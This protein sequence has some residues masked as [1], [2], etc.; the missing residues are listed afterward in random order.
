MAS[1]F[2]TQDALDAWKLTQLFIN[3]VQDGWFLSSSFE[4][5]WW[6]DRNPFLKN[7]DIMFFVILFC[8]LSGLCTQ[9]YSQV[10]RLWPFMPASYGWVLAL[11]SY[12]VDGDLDQRLWCM[13]LLVNFWCFRLVY[14]FHRKGGYNFHGEDYRWPYLRA[15]INNWFLMEVFNLTFIAFYQHV[16]LFLIALPLYVAY[17]T[18]CKEWQPLDTVAAV[19]LFLS[20]VGETIADQQQWNFH[21]RKAAAK[22]KAQAKGLKTIEDDKDNDVKRGFLS[23]SGLFYYSRHPNFFFEQ[24]VWWCLCIFPI[25]ITTMVKCG[26]PN[27]NGNGLYVHWSMMGAFL[28]SLLFQG[29]TW[30]T[31]KISLEKY[32][33]YKEYQETTSCLIPL[34]PKTLPCSKT[35]TL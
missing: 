9:N 28:L 4:T 3:Q 6:L 18:P 16:L 23:S 24:S 21:Q 20:V 25:S 2:L 27:S 13:N 30:L 14:N 22:S 15:K 32:P 11:H 8:W 7:L 26:S 33:L 31:E 1:L 17:E 10:D 19:L 35:K 12:F 34:P 29:S 5:A